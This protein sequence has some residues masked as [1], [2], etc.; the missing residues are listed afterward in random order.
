MAPDE[1][2]TATL[3]FGLTEVV[4]EW[5]KGTKFGDICQITDVQEGSIVRI[6]VRLD[7][8]CRDV[9]NAARIMGDSALYEKMESASQQS[10]VTLSSAHLCTFLVHKMPIVSSREWLPHSS[11]RVIYVYQCIMSLVSHARCTSLCFLVVATF[12]GPLLPEV[13]FGA[14][15]TDVGL[16]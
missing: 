15:I 9:R 8:M 12:L 2:V 6:I 7:E 11:S 1:F 10:S 16:P 14:S 13:R 5:A 3:R 4:H